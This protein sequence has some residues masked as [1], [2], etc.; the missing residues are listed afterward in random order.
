MGCF[1]VAFLALG[2]IIGASAAYGIKSAD[3]HRGKGVS[4]GAPE[5]GTEHVSARVLEAFGIHHQK[6]IKQ[7]RLSVVESA[8]ALKDGKIDALFGVGASDCCHP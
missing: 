2:S 4:L 8:E 1:W 6:D 5:R 3:F 7:D